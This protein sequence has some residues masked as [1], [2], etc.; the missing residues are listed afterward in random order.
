MIGGNLR[1]VTSSGAGAIDLEGRQVPKRRVGELTTGA[2]AGTG[3]LDLL[4]QAGHCDR[5]VTGRGGFLGSWRQDL[6]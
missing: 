4:A 5:A 2:L 1:A 3:Y 6:I